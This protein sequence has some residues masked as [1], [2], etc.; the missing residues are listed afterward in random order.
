MYPT[1]KIHTEGILLYKNFFKQSTEVGV[2]PGKNA[3]MTHRTL[4]QMQDTSSKE[5]V[6]KQKLI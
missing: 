4:L 5:R 2:V 1:P 6:R 3:G